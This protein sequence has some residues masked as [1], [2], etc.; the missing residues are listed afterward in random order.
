LFT[1]W[2]DTFLS[3]FLSI[4]GIGGLANID[5]VKKLIPT[6]SALGSSVFEE[7]IFYA[8][9]IASMQLLKNIS[10]LVGKWKEKYPLLGV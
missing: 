7:A 9:I 1:R 10:V 4:S 5:A 8:F 6:H 3:S 2:L